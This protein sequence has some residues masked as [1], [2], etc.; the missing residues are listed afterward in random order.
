MNKVRD[1]LRKKL[2][3][4]KLDKIPKFEKWDELPKELKL[5]CVNKLDFKT[6][7]F[8]R[9]TSRKERSLIDSQRFD[10]EKICLSNGSMITATYLDSDKKG[11][12]FKTCSYEYQQLDHLLP[13]L[14]Y[15]LRR[16]NIREFRINETHPLNQEELDKFNKLVPIGTA[17]IKN[18]FADEYNETALYFLRKCWKQ[19]DE[20]HIFAYGNQN[21]FKDLMTVPAFDHALVF[22]TADPAS[23][24]V[25][26]RH[27]LPMIENWIVNNAP[28]GKKLV[29]E[30]INPKTKNSF[31]LKFKNRVIY[32]GNID[33][34]YVIRLSTN[35]PY[36]HIL[37]GFVQLHN[38]VFYCTVVDSETE[39][40]DY[41]SY[42]C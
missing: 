3:Q 16:C 17:H 22:K 21:Y 12:E 19:V 39:L 10:F 4:M 40:S 33:V 27:F 35:H 20:V 26:V 11:H 32:Q 24:G 18:L 31:L 6:R 29:A 38:D 25:H 8:L 15:M 30:D 34:G 28:V 1:R 42:L 23:P 14:A 5:E 37:A 41:D 2:E 7:W 36:K 9:G 13:L